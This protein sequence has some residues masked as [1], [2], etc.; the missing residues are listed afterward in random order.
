MSLECGEDEWNWYDN[1]HAATAMLMIEHILQDY[2][3][4]WYF[5]KAM[6]LI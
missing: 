4:H 2:I 3:S 1:Q 6:S 5:K